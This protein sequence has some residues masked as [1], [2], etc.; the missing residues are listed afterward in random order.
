M[1]SL[2]KNSFILSKVII[3]LLLC[4]NWTTIFALDTLY[5]E[6]G[7]KEL[8]VENFGYIYIEEKDEL[9]FEKIKSLPDNLFRP[10]RETGVY[11]PPANRL[12]W[13]KYHIKNNTDSETNLLLVCRDIT[14]NQLQIFEHDEKGDIKKSDLTGDFFKF[15]SREIKHKFYLFNVKIPAGETRTYFAFI[16]KYRNPLWLQFKVEDHD[17]FYEE[18]QTTSFFETLYLGALYSVCLISL[19]FISFN[20]QKVFLYFSALCFITALWLTYAM[21]YGFKYIWFDFND[22]NNYAAP[23][24]QTLHAIVMTALTRAYLNTNK[25]LPRAD[26]LLQYIQYFF[27]FFF[28]Y[29]LLSS[30][31]PRAWDA[32]LLKVSILVQLIY[33]ITIIL[34]IT[35]A[36]RTTRQKELLI[37]LIAFL[38]TFVG[39]VCLSLLYMGLLN[40]DF[41]T[42]YLLYWLFGIDLLTLV[43]LL[44]KRIQNTFKEKTVLQA[45]LNELKINAAGALIEGQ[46]QERKRLSINLHDGMNLRLAT[47]KMRLSNLFLQKTEKEQK[48]EVKDLIQQVGN[49]SDDL[50]SFTHELSPLDL[51]EQTLDEAIEDL[52]YRVENARK[53]I[54]IAFEIEEEIKLQLSDLQTHVVYQVIQELLNNAL[55]HAKA[56]KIE[57]RLSSKD[58]SIILS[59]K[60]NGKGFNLKS[61]KNGIGLKNIRMRADFLSG[62]FTACSNER[63]SHFLF[64]FSI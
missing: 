54:R 53:N 24:F 6:E 8:N 48:T 1:Q 50:R 62:D 35:L 27:A 4:S 16:D 64:T 5:I 28:F 55:K 26:K 3:I 41:G 42:Q 40:D 34:I 61:K 22:F 45:R 46:Q 33:P 29:N 13:L 43:Y 49:I 58:E 12:H 10:V 36:Y 25:Y 15:S 17:Y 32:I 2:K 11:F 37:F 60:D 56:T 44:S 31:T 30:F 18:N 51:R 20:R 63:G 52:I 23:F 59:V 14:V 47:V 38:F 57:L 9:N 39:M 21:G 7:F 19:I